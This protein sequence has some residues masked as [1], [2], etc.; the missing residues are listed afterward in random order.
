MA[1]GE[2]RTAAICTGV[3]GSLGPAASATVTDTPAAATANR[4]VPPTWGLRRST[5][6]LPT[7]PLLA[8]TTAV[9]GLEAGLGSV[10]SGVS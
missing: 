3:R 6:G 7:R 1:E 4:A 8:V 9:A 2:A 5:T 10:T